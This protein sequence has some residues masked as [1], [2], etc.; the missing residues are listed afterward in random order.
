MSRADVVNDLATVPPVVTDPLVADFTANGFK[1]K[2]LIRNIFT[3]DDFVK[4]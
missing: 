3:A 1:L 4:F 2:R